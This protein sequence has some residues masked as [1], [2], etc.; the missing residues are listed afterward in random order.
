MNRNEEFVVLKIKNRM[1]EHIHIREDQMTLEEHIQRLMDVIRTELS[2]KYVRFFVF[3][4]FLKNHEQVFLSYITNSLSVINDWKGKRWSHEQKVYVIDSPIRV[5]ECKKGLLLRGKK[6]PE[7]G[8]MLFSFG[9]EE[10]RRFSNDF[11]E[12]LSNA[13]YQFLLGSIELLGVLSEKRRYQKLQRVTNEFYSSMDM[14][15][16]LEEVMQSL[17]EMYPSFSYQLLLSNY[18]SNNN[19]LPIQYL[20]YTEQNTALMDSFLS[21]EFRM[22]DDRRKKRSNLYFPMKGKQG[23]YGVLQITANESI[24]IGHQD[25]EFISILAQTASNA[26]ENAHLYQQSKKL[27]QELQ[28]VMKISQQLNSNLHLADIVKYIVKEVKHSFHADEVGFVLKQ[29]EGFTV[30]SGSTKYFFQKKIEEFLPFVETFFQTKKDSLFIGH[31]SQTNYVKNFPYN[32]L[33]AE[34]IRQEGKIIGFAICLHRNP[35]HFSFESFK[36]YQ[37]ITHH[38][39]LALSNTL[40]RE[41]LERLVITDYLTKLYSRN[42]LDEQLKQSMEKDDCGAFLLIDID[43]FKSINDTYGHQV[44]DEV[45]IQIAN[46]ILKTIGP[47]G[48]GARWGGEEIVIYLPNQSLDYALKL[49][50]NIVFLTKMETNPKVTISC[51]V[52]FWTK[53]REDHPLK[54]FKRADEALYMA[55]NR[56]KNRALAYG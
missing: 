20:D 18:N 11:W 56:G 41:E 49:A 24:V 10:I 25:I 22:E 43:D 47:S 55:K 2:V 48:I 23:V 27:I 35:Y 50:E 52:S 33:M 5:G 16:V 12:H 13:I 29:T 31:F 37:S 53:E 15:K 8:M 28:L 1:F 30:L 42:F 40:F 17:K 46:I 44:G 14:E 34:P 6:G 26:I 3:K 54:L 19:R 4:D 7:I 39:S 51:G 45:L 38:T 36:L 21:G 32:S 9:H